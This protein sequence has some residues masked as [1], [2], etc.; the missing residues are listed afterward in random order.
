MLQQQIILALGFN[1]SSGF[2][3]YEK[4]MRLGLGDLGSISG[5]ILN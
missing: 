5:C 3:F 4:K 1:S 2:V